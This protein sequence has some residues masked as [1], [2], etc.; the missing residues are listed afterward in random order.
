[1]AQANR[2]DSSAVEQLIREVCRKVPFLVNKLTKFQIYYYI[3][4]KDVKDRVTT[5]FIVRVNGPE[6]CILNK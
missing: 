4:Y 3:I 5:I 1:M 2:N 6:F